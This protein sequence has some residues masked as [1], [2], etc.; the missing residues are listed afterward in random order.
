MIISISLFVQ[1]LKK[2]RFLSEGL[3]LFLMCKPLYRGTVITYF[4]KKLKKGCHPSHVGLNGLL[5]TGYVGDGLDKGV[6][7][8]K[9]ADQRFWGVL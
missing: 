1:L 4:R 9:V 2:V 6:T 7:G 5:S 8:K 3:H